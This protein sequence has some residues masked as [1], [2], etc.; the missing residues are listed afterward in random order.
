MR[1]L[2]YKKGQKILTSSLCAHP[3]TIHLQITGRRDISLV[4]EK[5]MTTAVGGNLRR[6]LPKKNIRH[7][8]LL[9]NQT[10]IKYILIE[11]ELYNREIKVVYLY[12]P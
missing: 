3:P 5:R 8:H 4:M 12:G 7:L 2:D 11:P 9:R 10:A 1:G 6:S